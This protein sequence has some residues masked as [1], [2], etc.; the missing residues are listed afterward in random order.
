MEWFRFYN[1]ALHDPKVQRLAPELFRTWINLLCLASATNNS[2]RLPGIDD[3]AFALRTTEDKAR[4]E[5]QALIKAGLLDEDED[6]SIAPHN[7]SGR[8]RK[9]DDVTARVQDHRDRKRDEKKGCNVSRNDGC[10]VSQSK[11]ETAS[12]APGR[13]R[14]RGQEQNR[15]DTEQ[16]RD[17]T[18]RERD[19]GA[20]I[21]LTS[22]STVPDDDPVVDRPRD[23]QSL[24]G[25]IGQNTAE[26]VREALTAARQVDPEGVLELRLPYWLTKF[27]ARFVTE[28]IWKGKGKGTPSSYVARIIDRGLPPGWAEREAA[29]SKPPK[30]RPEDVILRAPDYVREAAMARMKRNVS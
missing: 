8:Q 16:S 29:A 6:G 21:P 19:A 9:S 4:D 27:P 14:P 20:K 18:E 2:G 24:D 17:R 22:M 26:A 3:I 28:S 23:T 15:T 10:N 5:V 25:P 13:D 12:R 1:A 7:W 11:S 30:L